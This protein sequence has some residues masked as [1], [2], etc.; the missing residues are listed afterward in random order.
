[1]PLPILKL[2]NQLAR[3][4]HAF[5]ISNRELDHNLAASNN[6]ETDEYFM[7]SCAKREMSKLVKFKCITFK[8]NF[9]V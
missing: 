8:Q 7:H 4:S 6:K 9:S 2:L 5:A 3:P 1:M